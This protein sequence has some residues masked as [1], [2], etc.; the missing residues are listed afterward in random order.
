MEVLNKHLEFTDGV[1]DR[2]PA[3]C[4]DA[5]GACGQL[6]HC[7][8]RLCKQAAFYRL[9]ST[10]PLL[11]HV[12]IHRASHNTQP[13]GI[14]FFVLP[15]CSTPYVQTHRASHNTQPSGIPFF[16]LPGCSL[17]AHPPP[18]PSTH[19]SVRVNDA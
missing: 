3:G 4:A 11:T 8:S 15:D 14:P 16:V 5:V 17:P 1:H 19:T 12:Q 9:H 6:M 7:V 2:L 10:N 13:S 18:L